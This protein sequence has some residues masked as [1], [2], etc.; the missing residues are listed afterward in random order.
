MVVELLFIHPELP[1]AA[2]LNFICHTSFPLGFA[3]VEIA[4]AVK[5]NPATLTSDRICFV[6]L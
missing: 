3:I 1:F 6:L 2:F 5:K 4:K